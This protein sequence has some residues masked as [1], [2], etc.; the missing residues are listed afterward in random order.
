MPVINNTFCVL[1]FRR[2]NMGSGACIKIHPGYV[3][4]AAIE[5][6][7]SLAQQYDGA[8]AWKQ[9]GEPAVGEL[10]LPEVLISRR[11]V[12]EMHHP[13]LLSLGLG[14]KGHGT[15]EAILG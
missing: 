9:H 11:G 13:Q 8:V 3:W 7:Q 14:S 1:A 12:A 2:M 15:I 6:A 4:T 10:G 5:K